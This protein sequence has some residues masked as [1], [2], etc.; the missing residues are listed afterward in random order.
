MPLA[1]T[2]MALSAE[3]EVAATPD[4]SP[5]EN[6]RATDPHRPANT[7]PHPG[8][9]AQGPQAGPQVLVRASTPLYPASPP[10]PSTSLLPCTKGSPRRT[11]PWPGVPPSYLRVECRLALTFRTAK[12]YT[13]ST[14]LRILLSYL[15][16][17]PRRRYF[18]VW[19][20][21]YRALCPVGAAQ[22]NGAGRQDPYPSARVAQW[23]RSRFVIGRL[24]GSNPLSGSS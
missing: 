8:L 23:Q 20:I 5:Q 14:T 6:P 16:R 17:A 12:S 13:D 9:P 10:S 7:S 3:G 11:A 15:L 2:G 22:V 1:A 18:R 21:V 4:A 19:D 24:A